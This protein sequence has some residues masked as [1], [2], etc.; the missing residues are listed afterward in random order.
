MRAHGWS[1]FWYWFDYV[2]CYH[3]IQFDFHNVLERMRNLSGWV[4]LK[5]C[6]FVNID[7]VNKR[8]GASKTFQILSFDFLA[9]W[10]QQCEPVLISS[11]FISLGKVLLLDQQKS[12]HLLNMRSDFLYL[13]VRSDLVID[14][15]NIN[16][17][18]SFPLNITFVSCDG[19]PFIPIV[20]KVFCSYSLNMQGCPVQTY[21]FYFKI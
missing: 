6:C 21:I 15:G 18:I 10:A 5:L 13:T 2:H 11:Q 4:N 16:H 20:L 7:I 9:C 17:C 14:S 12:L 8:F 1:R 3:P 19:Y